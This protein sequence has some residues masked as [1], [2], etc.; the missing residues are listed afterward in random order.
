M[1]SVASVILK[2]LIHQNPS[3]PA[4]TLAKKAF[5]L[6]PDL[7]K[8]IESCRASVRYYLGISGSRS[9]DIQA[10]QELHREP[11]K[12]GSWEGLLPTP[13]V[14]LPNWHPLECPGPF[15]ALLLP[16]IHIPFYNPNALEIALD[17]GLK[18]KPDY[19]VL[20]GD[21]MDAYAISKFQRSPKLRNFP[22]EVQASRQF[23]T[24]LRKR[25]PKS[26]IIYKQG[27]HEERWD[28]FILSNCPDFQGVD[29]FE[30]EN[31]FWLDKLKIEYIKDKR[32]I[33]LGKLNVLHGHE[34]MFRGSGNPIVPARWLFDK[35]NDHALCSH[36]HQESHYSK[37]TVQQKLIGCWSTGCLCNLNPD[38]MPHNNWCNGFAWVEIEKDGAFH[39]YNPRIIHDR[40]W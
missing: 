7:W 19:V 28:T 35:T 6:R 24:S 2:S 21:I 26:R 22:E 29:S 14:S 12:A 8:D 17:Y 34:Y 36:F 38:W 13:K 5:G 27:N 10:N 4:L 23:L 20:N 39:V 11:R 25:F 18:H 30:F 16:D 15:S 37:K 33:R 9:R 1:P 31:V 3:L 32:P 40:I